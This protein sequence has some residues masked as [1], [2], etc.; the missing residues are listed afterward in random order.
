MEQGA[1]VFAVDL[2]EELLLQAW[3]HHPNVQ[4]LRHCLA[5]HFG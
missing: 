4:P 3:S 5:L 2:N 1:F